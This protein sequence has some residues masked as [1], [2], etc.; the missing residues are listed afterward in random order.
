MVQSL[1]GIV[2]TLAFPLG[3]M[4]SLWKVLSRGETYFKLL[5]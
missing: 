1:P 2:N 5:F 4:G 3:V